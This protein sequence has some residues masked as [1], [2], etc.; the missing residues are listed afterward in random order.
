MRL[1]PLPA[2]WLGE[3]VVKAAAAKGGGMQGLRGRAGGVPEAGKGLGMAEVLQ[4][5]TDAARAPPECGVAA[6]HARVLR[7]WRQRWG[8]LGTTPSQ[9]DDFSSQGSATEF[10][11]SND[12]R[13]GDRDHDDSGGVHVSPMCPRCRYL[14]SHPLTPLPS[15]EPS[16][17]GS[18][19]S[20]SSSTSCSTAAA[21]DVTLGRYCLCTVN[22]EIQRD[23][24]QGSN[25]SSH[26]RSAAITEGIGSAPASAPPSPATG[27]DI[28]TP[29]LAN[30]KSGDETF[31]TTPTPEGHAHSGSPGPSR[32]ST[33]GGEA[34][35]TAAA[36][37]T[38]TAAAESG[39]SAVSLD[40]A[41]RASGGVPSA[42]SGGGAAERRGTSGG[43]GGLGRV[44]SAHTF[45]EPGLFMAT[46]SGLASGAGA[47][48]GAKRARD[49]RADRRKKKDPFEALEERLLD[50]FSLESITKQLRQQD[51]T[52][53]KGVRHVE[54]MKSREHTT[55]RRSNEEHQR[56]LMIQK[57]RFEAVVTDSL[58]G[59]SV[60]AEEEEEEA[61]EPLASDPNP[62]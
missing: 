47:I 53:Q 27:T 32:M 3:A 11:G 42:G 37:A 31:I 25:S 54:R 50:G 57:K 10:D 30:I 46:V 16:H 45:G 48:S 35:A 44:P 12:G 5:M 9:A 56:H 20:L 33:P 15:T 62:A 17:S 61:P 8:R 23:V 36:A 26:T 6:S 13:D 1:S 39:E 58:A 51:E 19:L 2:V 41:T 14:T 24:L 18:S 7:E 22:R 60:E 34:A 52:L 43:P 49:R 29:S 59:P 55:G 4:A 28:G 38:A 40:G 21:A